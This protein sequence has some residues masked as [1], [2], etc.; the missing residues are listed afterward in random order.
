MSDIRERISSLKLEL[1]EYSQK[2]VS[3]VEILHA[4]N[5][6]KTPIDFKNDPRNAVCFHYRFVLLPCI[7]FPV[8]TPFVSV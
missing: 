5:V 8:F 4:P 3:H 6:G 1:Q 7:L 2:I